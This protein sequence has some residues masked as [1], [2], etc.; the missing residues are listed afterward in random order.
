MYV[1]GVPLHPTKV[2]VTVIV[3]VTGEGVEF[4][5][6]KE[7]TEPLPEAAK[8]ILGE[9][10]IQLYVAPAVPENVTA[11]VVIPEHSV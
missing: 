1:S 3:A 4:T 5:A 7:G 2:G 9:L 10:F 11:A 6:I 8:P